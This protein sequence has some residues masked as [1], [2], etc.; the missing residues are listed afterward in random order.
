[1]CRLHLHRGCTGSRI[2]KVFIGRVRALFAG[3]W[4]IMLF[5]DMMILL[6]Y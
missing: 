2:C 3:G 1:M 6:S 5:Y 4:V